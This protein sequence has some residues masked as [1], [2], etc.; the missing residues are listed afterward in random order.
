MLRTLLRLMV[1]EDELVHG[2]ED[3]LRE[4]LNQNTVVPFEAAS[5]LFFLSRHP[6]LLE[7]NTHIPIPYKIRLSVATFKLNHS[8]EK[9]G[10]D[11]IWLHVKKC[12]A[13]L[14]TY[15]K[16]TGGRLPL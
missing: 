14:G 16:V 10:I 4:L 8:T 6:E 9:M 3:R 1:Q 7:E 12:D 5:S 15:A 11:D 2:L 13:C